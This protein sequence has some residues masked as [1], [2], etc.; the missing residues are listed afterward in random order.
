MPEAV[1][2]NSSARLEQNAWITRVL[3]FAFAHQGRSAVDWDS[4]RQA[5]LDAIEATNGQIAAL[6]SALKTENDPDLNEISKSGSTPL[7][8]A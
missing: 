5:W 8:A 3:G 6:Q 4:V 1:N 2:P 7:P